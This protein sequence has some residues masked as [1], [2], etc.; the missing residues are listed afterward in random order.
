MP[1]SSAR[2]LRATRGQPREQRPVHE[3]RTISAMIA[4]RSGSSAATVKKTQSATYCA[5]V[6]SSSEIVFSA[7]GMKAPGFADAANPGAF[8]PIALKTI[9]AAP[10]DGCAVRRRLGL[11]HRR[12]AAPASRRDHRADRAPLVGRACPR[13]CPRVARRARADDRSRDRSCCSPSRS[14]GTESRG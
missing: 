5:A 1:R 6:G 14:C 3:R 2:A 7:I 13:G 10:P 9:S 12:G 4:T 11:L 8:I